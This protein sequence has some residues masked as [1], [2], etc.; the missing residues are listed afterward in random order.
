MSV[1]DGVPAEVHC[2][3]DLQSV[4]CE[5]CLGRGS[6]EAD[7]LNDHVVRRERCYDCGGGGFQVE[8]RCPNCKDWTLYWTNR[9]QGCN[10]CEYEEDPYPQY[11]KEA[12][13]EVKN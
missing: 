6:V 4:E 1:F 8:R 2:R 12:I 9:G 7:P 3:D 13:E 10:Q 5:R 11:R